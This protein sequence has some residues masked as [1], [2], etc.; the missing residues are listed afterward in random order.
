MMA[1]SASDELQ[2]HIEAVRRE[3]FAAGYAA[4]MAAIREFANRPVSGNKISAVPKRNRSAVAKTSRSKAPSRPRQRAAAATTR[5][6]DRKPASRPKHGT[7]ARLVEEVLQA[8]A[9]RALRPAEIRTALQ[10]D[11][12]VAISFTSVRHALS[13]LQARA[14]AEQNDDGKSWRY[15]AGE[16]AA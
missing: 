8:N 15:R 13:Q 7:N 12:G 6:T 5:R 1:K 14:S 4:G 9:P 11:K 2:Q 10:H 3:A 16:A